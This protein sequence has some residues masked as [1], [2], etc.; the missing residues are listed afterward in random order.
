MLVLGVEALAKNLASEV[1][2]SMG[3]PIVLMEEKGEDKRGLVMMSSLLIEML[4]LLLP[5]ADVLGPR[6]SS[7]Y[8]AGL[9]LG[10]L[11]RVT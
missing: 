3:S 11:G 10:L 9:S 8:K 2:P 4:F 6:P 7:R 5:S 1:L